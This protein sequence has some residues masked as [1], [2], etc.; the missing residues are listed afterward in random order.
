VTADE[1]LTTSPMLFGYCGRSGQLAACDARNG[2]RFRIASDRAAEII[3]AFLDPR[4][5][6]S[7]EEDGFS[8]EEL[9]EAVDA[10][11]LISDR[12]SESAF[13]WERNGWSRPAFLTFSQMDIPFREHEGP[14][15]DPE[16][17]AERRREA[18]E[19]YG[20]GRHDPEPRLL[21]S[22]AEVELPP[23]PRATP[24]LS[25]LTS[26]R[27]IRAFSPSPPT[28]EQLG[29]VLHAATI[30]LR[31]IADRRAN[32]DDSLRLL[33][34]HFT[35]AHL[36]VVVQAVEGIPRGVFEYDWVN[37][38]L[39]QAAEPPTDDALVAAIQGMRWV[40]GTGFTVFVVADLRSL[41]WL[42]RHSRA[43]LHVL[44]QVGE[45]GQELLMAATELGLGGWTSPA[46]H[47]SRT[48]KL[49]GLPDDDAVDALSMVKLGRPLRRRPRNGVAPPEG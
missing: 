26:R 5:V 27:S 11:I 24:R 20:S 38:G 47:E 30:D 17:V 35:F 43:Y 23:P 7:A 46:V 6:G 42:Y 1:V 32:G 18:V 29:G 36:F 49:L 8:R 15:D 31:A 10:G 21:A 39:V 13:L 4:S 41:A 33:D 44:I 2:R 14:A 9:Q 48:A 22:G 34:S 45:L 3:N 19:E 37:H 12:E 40:L 28:T 16:T 25:A